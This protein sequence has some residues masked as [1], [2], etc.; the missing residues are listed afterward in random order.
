MSFEELDGFAL[1]EVPEAGGFIEA[2][3]ETALAVARQ[4][5]T[6]D[7]MRVA[8]H[9]SLFLAGLDVPEP[10]RAIV[11]AGENPLAVNRDGDRAD[12]ILVTC[13]DLGADAGVI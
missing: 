2:G 10:Y 12:I 5:D 13:K 3:R 7:G 8:L 4:G 11:A 1:F 9:G 6:P